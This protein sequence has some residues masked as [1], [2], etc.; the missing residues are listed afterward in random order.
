[1]QLINLDYEDM[2]NLYI[3]KNASKLYQKGKIALSMW[4]YL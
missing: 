3:L 1:M 2:K 4:D